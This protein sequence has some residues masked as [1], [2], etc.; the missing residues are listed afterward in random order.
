V[1]IIVDAEGAAA[2]RDLIE[3]GKSKQLRAQADK[4]GGYSAYMTL[5][6]DYLEAL[7]ARVRMRAALEELL[8]R[9]DAVVAPTRGNVALPIGYD[10][11]KG[12]SPSPSPSPT[13]A[14]SPGADRPAPPATIAAGNLTGVPAV[15]VP[16]GFGPHGLPTSLQFLGRAFSEP[17][18][19]AIADRYQQA[20][21]WHTHRPPDPA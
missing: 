12:P 14:P 1:G 11:D 8:S 10:F 20:T 7:R 6:V 9:Y 17:T 18:L 3:S 4:L 13:P 16:N 19:L 2:F 5:A 21:D 15:C